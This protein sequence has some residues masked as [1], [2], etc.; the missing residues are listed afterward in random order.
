MPANIPLGKPT[1]ALCERPFAA[2]GGPHNAEAGE[3]STRSIIDER[4]ATLADA[5]S[6]GSAVDLMEASSC[7]SFAAVPGLR[8][9]QAAREKRAIDSRK[10]SEVHASMRSTAWC[11]A[12]KSRTA[13]V[14]KVRR[15]LRIGK[16]GNSYHVAVIP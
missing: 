16:L 5:N 12:E 3:R 6:A 10:T 14:E 13:P 11:V 4:G 7:R 1:A 9:P 2:A 15:V 8:P